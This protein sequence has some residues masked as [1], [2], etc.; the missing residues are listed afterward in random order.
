VNEMAGDER[1]S[2]ERLLGQALQEDQQVYILAF[3]PGVVP[4]ETT[5]R[6]ALA[7]MQQAFTRSQQHA[8]QHGLADEEIDEAVDEATDR[9]RYGTS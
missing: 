5:R 9:I 3:R 1:R 7:G 2:V 4:D 8:E 6:R